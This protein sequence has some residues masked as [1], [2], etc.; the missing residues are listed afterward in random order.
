M[1]STTS[2]NQ[3]EITQHSRK[4]CDSALANES[5]HTHQTGKAE[6]LHN[7]ANVM[8]RVYSYNVRKNLDGLK[9]Y[10]QGNHVIL[11]ELASLQL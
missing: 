10:S 8:L 4:Q 1:C 5:N 6:T 2:L 9:G 3:M 11:Q 7:L